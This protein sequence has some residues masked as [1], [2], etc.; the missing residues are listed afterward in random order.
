MGE[1]SPDFFRVFCPN[2]PIHYAH[3]WLQAIICLEAEVAVGSACV[4]VWQ[5]SI[6]RQRCAIAVTGDVRSAKTRQ[7]VICPNDHWGTPVEKPSQRSQYCSISD[8]VHAS[9]F[10][11]RFKSYAATDPAIT[12]G[13]AG[14]DRGTYPVYCW[15]QCRCARV[16]L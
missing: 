10:L 1:E 13:L 3:T 4:P 7:L 6:N 8:L 15:G 9:T 5:S 11:G 14:G 12:V 16:E 2:R